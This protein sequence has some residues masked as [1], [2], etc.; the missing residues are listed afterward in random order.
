[1]RTPFNE[2]D[3]CFLCKLAGAGSVAGSAG[4]TS[5]YDDSFPYH[6]ISPSNM[7]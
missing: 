1:M 6:S 4:H 2:N 7:K 5:N 3:L